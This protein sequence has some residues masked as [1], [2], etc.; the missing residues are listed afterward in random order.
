MSAGIRLS[1]VVPAYDNGRTLDETLRSILDQEVEGL[2]LIV[3]DH[4][5]SDDTL[6]VMRRFADDPRVTLLETEAGGGAGRNWNRVTEAAR[7]ELIKLVCGDDVLRPGVLARQAAL[8]ETTGAV[9]TACRRDLIDMNG[10]VLLA[11][12]GLRGLDRRMPGAEAVRRA[13]RAG[14]NLFGE[15]ASVMMRRD[16]LA[17]TGGWFDRFSYLIDQATYTR[18][19]LEGDFVPDPEVGATFRMSDS[20]WSVALASRQ[21]AEA[22]EFHAW[23]REA[24]PEV[25]SGLDRRIGDVRAALMARARRLSYRVLK[26]RMR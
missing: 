4:A 7:G 20:Q 1:V 24:H 15:P 3:A 26:R 8:L 14:S 9:M 11:G 13:V 22:R 17:R 25:L 12:W 5:S 18:V 16:V 21:S 19:L 6:D 23:V 2:E 10:D